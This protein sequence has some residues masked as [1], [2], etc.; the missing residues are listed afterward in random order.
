MGSYL[1]RK[2][3]SEAFIPLEPLEL[4]VEV[5]DVEG[6]GEVDVGIASVAQ[7]LHAVSQQSHSLTFK[8]MGR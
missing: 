7:G 8:S 2:A 3:V 6:V 4:E 5:E 1:W